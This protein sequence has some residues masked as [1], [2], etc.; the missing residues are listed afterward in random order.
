MIILKKKMAQSYF[1]LPLSRVGSW[2]TICQRKL[3][4]PPAELMK[5]PL[6]LSSPPPCSSLFPPPFD[7]LAVVDLGQGG[8]ATSGV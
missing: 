1:F 8:V 4:T 7:N 6:S 2:K 5:S 3:D